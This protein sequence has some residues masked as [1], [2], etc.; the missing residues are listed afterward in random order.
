MEPIFLLAKVV[1]M[2]DKDSDKANVPN[3]DKSYVKLAT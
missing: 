2:S 1:A 3:I